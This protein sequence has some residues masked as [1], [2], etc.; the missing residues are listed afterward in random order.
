MMYGTP[1]A[2]A[3]GWLLGRPREFVLHGAKYLFA[4]VWGTLTRGVPTAYGA[5]S[6]NGVIACDLSLNR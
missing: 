5:V 1:L 3:E 4:P 2:S 6:L